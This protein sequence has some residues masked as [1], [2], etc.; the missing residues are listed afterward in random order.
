M[1]IGPAFTRWRYFIYRQTTCIQLFSQWQRPTLHRV[2]IV[3]ICY[4]QPCV[5]LA[6]FSESFSISDKS[7]ILQILP[8]KILVTAGQ[9]G[10]PYE[11]L[12]CISLISSSSSS[13]SSSGS[14]THKH[15]TVPLLTA[16]PMLGRSLFL[17]QNKILTLVLPNLNLSP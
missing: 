17:L 1:S 11:Y 6:W 3:D 4:W 16:K 12:H 8:T 2:P 14:K 7:P 15:K 10:L 9:P 5:T 13:S